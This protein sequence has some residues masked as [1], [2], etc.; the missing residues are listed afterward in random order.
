MDLIVSHMSSVDF[1]RHAYP[2]HKELK[3]PPTS[4]QLADELAVNDADVWSLAPS[5]VTPEFLEPEGGVLHVLAREGASRRTARH[6]VAHQWSGPIPNGGLYSFGNGAY[7]CSPSFAFLQMARTVNPYELVAYGCELCGRYAFDKR[8]ERGFHMRKTPLA[9]MEQLRQLVQDAPGTRGRTKAL[10]ALA[11]IIEGS[12][13]PRETYVAL[14]LTLPYRDG[15]YGL[16]RMKMN[17]R[18]DLSPASAALCGKRNV[19]IDLC[20]PDANLAIEYLGEHDHA[21]GAAMRA[22]RGRTF[23]LEED[24]YK[25]IEIT[26][27]QVNDIVTFEAIA[28][29]IAAQIGK[30]V[31]PAGRGATE[32]RME[33]RR[34]LTRWS[35]SDGRPM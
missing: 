16:P 13:S 4:P 29:R 11:R 8:A 20:Y 35:K 18:I 6:H 26:A 31:K 10:W 32:A 24:G 5:W 15:G 27:E 21:N 19:Y 17:Q 23:A 22:D 25:V 1:W 2:P 12:A 30:T 3:P 7:V 9:T 14:L 33:L 34:L 28:L